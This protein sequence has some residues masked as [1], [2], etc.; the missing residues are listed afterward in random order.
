M[1]SFLK[2][3]RRADQSL[4]PLDT[5]GNGTAPLE[6]LVVRAEAAADQLRSLLP[7]LERAAELD[8]LRERCEAVERDVAGID[9]L[10]AQLAAAEA[11]AEQVARTQTR[12]ETQVAH[13]GEDV[14]RIQSRMAELGHKVD[15]ALLLREALDAFLSPENPIA[16]LRSEAEALRTQVAEMGE[17]VGRIRAQHDD[18]LRAHRHTMSRLEAI[19]DEHQ[20]AAS[21]LEETARRLQSVERSLD[22]LT[23]ATDAIPGI[24]H[25]LAVL[26]SLAE[27]VAQKM[28]A[29][30]QQ[31]EAVDRAANQISKLTVLDRELDTWLRR[32]EEQIRRFSAIESRIADVQ[33]LQAKVLAHTNE[34]QASQ[35]V[36]ESA[37]QA[38]RQ[39]LVELREQMRKSSEG[40]ELE[41]RGLHA[42]SERVADLRSAVKECEARF[43]VLDAASQG[44]AAVQGQVRTLAEQ[45]GELSR[46]L[47]RLSEEARRIGGMRDDAERLDVLAAETAAR[48]QRVEELKPDL[49][50]AVQKLA[51]LKGTHE[52]LADGLERMRLAQDEIARLRVSHADTHSWLTTTDEW[53]RKVEGQ[54]NELSRMQPAVE[55]IR[56]E[57]EQVQTA[58]AGIESGRGMVEELQ[59]R[60]A[61]LGTLSDEVRDRMDGLGTRMDGAEVRF[62]QLSAEAEEARRVRETIAGVVASVAAAERRIGT[63]DDSVRG[64]ES[65]TQQLDELE[66]RVRLLGQEME[67]RQGALD[68]AT[69]HLNLASTLRQESAATAQRLEELSHTVGSMLET[70]EGRAA[71]IEQVAGDLEARAAALRAVDR[72]VSHFEELL[73]KW[74]SAQSEAARAMEQTLAR[75]GAVEALEAQVKHVFDLA[76]RSVEH[77]QTIGDARH[78]IEE[79]HALLQDTHAQLKSAEDRLQGFEARKRQLERTEQRLARAEAL[80][81]EVRSTVEALQAQRAVVDHAIERSGLLTFQMK[82]AEA[83]VETLRRERTLACDVSAAVASVRGED[84]EEEAT[85]R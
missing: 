55:R 52:M 48:L 67:Q 47:V 15:T 83:L 71:G 62:T 53:T 2:T 44:T 32:Q 74:E 5:N 6:A 65:R 11:Q 39:A 1:V 58:M 84:E 37:Q 7:I 18:A 25:Q 80:A 43:A 42:V 68:K 57:V 49:H 16:G 59:R 41:N 9:R 76:E 73:A 69:E 81:L 20:A 28:T 50:E 13:A 70:A 40:F 24:Q 23:Q 27:H 17:G 79:A 75:Q 60:L 14:E 45:S 3:R 66:E 29:V 36:A 56:S 21:R 63:V 82:Q 34:L 64:L 33:A 46:E 4:V 35:Q 30:E 19:D 31:R 51:A 26:K 8:S 61:E 54:V 38:A 12:T 85:S 78:Q 10:R 22:P 72:Q 77:A